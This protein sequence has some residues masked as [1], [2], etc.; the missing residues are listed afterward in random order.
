MRIS[1]KLPLIVVGCALAAAL[2]VGWFAYRSAEDE[3]HRAATDRL[4]A[5][6]ESRHAALQQ[7]FR[8][9]AEDIELIAASNPVSAALMGL[10]K[11]FG[12]FDQSDRFRVEK[13]L[14]EIFSFGK[15]AG[16]REALRAV[17]QPAYFEFYRHHNRHHRWFSTLLKVRGYHD[18]FLITT[19]GDIVYSGIKESDFASN[20]L[21][22]TLQDTAIAATFRKAMA[23]PDGA[24]LPVFADFT[25]Y[26]PSNNAPAAFV[27]KRIEAHGRV[28]GVLVLQLTIRRINDVMQVT[29]GMGDTGETFLVGP[30]R[31]MRSDS[32]FKNTGKVLDQPVNSSAV[33]RAFDGKVGVTEAK[34]YRGHPVLSAFR[35]FRFANLNWA[36]MAEI[37]LEEIYRPI[38]DL[39]GHLTNIVLIIIVVVS[40]MGFLFARTIAAPL[41]FVGAAMQRFGERRMVVDLP[42]ADRRDEIGDIARVFGQ[43]SREIE[44]HLENV[45]TAEA[46][47]AEKEAELRLALDN[48][49]DGIFM[50]DG[51]GRFL[52]VNERYR[53]MIGPRSDLVQVGLPMAGF[54]QAL[55]EDG[56]Y[57]DGDPSTLAEQRIERLMNDD[58]VTGTMHLPDGPVVE[59]RKAPR[60]GGGSVVIAT[61]VTERE[62]AIAEVAQRQAEMRLALD[63]M[64]D[65]IFMFDSDGKYLLFN[66]RYVDLAGVPDGLIAMGQPVKGVVDNLAYNGC[67]GEGDPEELSATRM[68]SL[69]SD[70]VVTGRIPFPSGRLLELRKAPRPGGGGI[71][72][73][74]DATEREQALQDVAR[75]R[76]IAETVFANMD[77]GITMFDDDLNLIA[78]NEKYF[79]LLELP[80]DGFQKGD[81][82]ADFF[83]YNAERGEYGPGDIDQQVAERVALASTFDAHRFERTR[84]DGVVLEIVGRPVA[85]GGF[86]STYTDISE[87]RQAEADIAEKEARLRQALDNMAG[88]IC[89]LD[90]D[91]NVAVYNQQ[92]VNLYQYDESEFGIGT[93][94]AEP[95]RRNAERGAHGPGHADRIV[96]ERLAL[97]RSAEAGSSERV[98]DD[99][100]ILHIR[101]NPLEGGG[102]VLVVTDITERKA[103]ERQIAEREKWFR[104]LL[105]S[106]PDATIITNRDGVIELVNRQALTLFGYE[107]HEL[108]G[109][110]IEVLVPEAYRDGHLAH[111]ESFHAS[112]SVRDMAQDLDLK[113]LHKSGLIFPAEISI[114]PIETSQGTMVAAAVRDITERKKAER[115]IAEREKW[116]RDLLES[117][118][119]ATIITNRDGVIELVNR[120]ALTLF[121]YEVHELVGEKIEVL[122]PE[123]YR[124]GHLAHRESFHASPAVRDMAQ[125]LDLKGRH[126]SGHIFPAEISISPIETSQGTMV[127]AAVR[128]IT[129]RKE[130][131]QALAE[132]QAQLHAAMEN[133]PGGIL[134]LDPDLNIALY[135]DQYPAIMRYPSE[136]FQIG[137]SIADSIRNTMDEEARNAP[138]A[139]AVIEARLGRLRASQSGESERAYG[140]G[141]VVHV[142]Y[143]ALKEGGLVLVATDIT[144][145]KRAEQEV[146]EKEAQLSIALDTMTGGLFMID[147][148]LNLVVFNKNFRDYYDMPDDV[149]RVGAP[150]EGV[151]RIRAERGEYGPGDPEQQV[152]D[153][154]DGYDRTEVVRYEDHIATTGRIIETFRTPTPDGGVVVV[155]NDVTERR[156]G[157]KQLQDAH[158]LITDSISYASRIQR[159]LLPTDEMFRNMFADHF[160]MWEPRDVVGGDL[161][162]VRGAG[163]A[164]LLIVA[165][166]TG[167][168]VPGA[169]MTMIATGALD[170]AL[171]ENPEGDPGTLIGQM[172]QL[173]QEALGQ[174]SSGGESDDGLELGIC[175]YDLADDGL[176]YAGARFSLL[177]LRDTDVEEWKGDRSGIGYRRVPGN[178]AFT[179]HHIEVEDGDAF[180]LWTDGFVDQIGGPKRRAFGKRRVINIIRDYHLMPMARQKAQLL[181]ELEE[182]QHNEVRRDDVTMVGFR[183]R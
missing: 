71:V 20:L 38:V 181:R 36:I 30:D 79:E 3:L 6:S 2:A 146:V 97:F 132:K 142:R 87:R 172:H 135:N 53:E 10:T 31:L 143:N 118:P 96:A 37:D 161:V 15:S 58:V 89:M 149:V 85:S 73:A 45:R 68:A 59:L 8:T 105:E 182:Y 9:V 66:Q 136:T 74:T 51:E 175:R 21:T 179:D 160:M 144:D 60:P 42:Q 91:M 100:R 98:F 78:C 29:A 176:T 4:M 122:V 110:K 54:I 183:P 69:L 152:R 34:G 86:V 18:V 24:L 48:M 127:A 126:K 180:Y 108:V 75:Q 120:Q 154:I 148:D 99:G 55:A 33:D 14:R 151:L 35:P 115:Q 93:P 103:A 116:F 80:S 65:G 173:V 128:D 117:T 164:V 169:F 123:A 106:T 109:E 137:R 22:G 133:M 111:R 49:A 101:H 70:Q 170:Q 166:C 162:W 76:E 156:T 165:D 57:G 155:F 64:A 11:A 95:I 147:K 88:G 82:I 130:A 150:L 50:L 163:S 157:E 43:V 83:R 77:Q 56:W 41:G 134:M 16:D 81:N 17:G 124:D 47:A 72:V 114:S 13:K 62:N 92:Y 138:D 27:G 178:Q 119:D 1:L 26:P 28:I 7:Y 145:R 140:D 121:G 112:P 40:I 174:D 46:E 94:I 141:S 167:H 125:D 52:L 61:D 5:L 158:E 32:R 63:N 159:A 153:R 19:R 139:D 90:A 44:S 168:G 102:V 171:R 84:P 131:E 129:A 25:K 104:D 12:N 67:Y 107:V 113:A 39:R 23:Q 177:R